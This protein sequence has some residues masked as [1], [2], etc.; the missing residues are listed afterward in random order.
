MPD[1]SKLIVMLK[2]TSVSASTFNVISSFSCSLP[3]HD[4]VELN[5][6]KLLSKVTSIF[7]DV[8]SENDVGLPENGLEMENL[9][10]TVGEY[11]DSSVRR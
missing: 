9:L 4:S 3:A 11:G 8:E 1:I 5:S 10:A 7:F 6:S 2:S